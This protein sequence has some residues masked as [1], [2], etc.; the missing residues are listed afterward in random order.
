MYGVGSN[1]P[2]G[3]ASSSPDPGLWRVRSVATRGPCPSRVSAAGAV[4]L[5]PGRGHLHPDVVVSCL[6]EGAHAVLHLPGFA[7]VGVNVDGGGVPGLP[8][9]QVVHG[10]S[11]QLALDVPECLVD[12]AEGVVQDG[13]VPPVRRDV[14]GL[15]NVLDV[16]RVLADHEGPEIVVDGGQHGCWALGEGGASNAVDLR[17]GRF[18]LHDYQPYAVGLGEDDPDV[19][20]ERV[21]HCF[22]PFRLEAPGPC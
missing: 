10:H 3:C 13:A 18:D 14:A 5:E 9:P 4:G 2:G 22:Y 16:A 12:A 11:G 21:G 20:D 7:A 1:I 6:R 17:L 15:P 19:P 8:A